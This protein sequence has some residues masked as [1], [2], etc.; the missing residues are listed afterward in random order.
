MTTDSTAVCIPVRG[1][2]SGL[3]RTLRSIDNL[4]DSCIRQI[5]VSVDG[6]DDELTSLARDA[7]ADTVVLPR[8]RGPSA[9][10]NAAIDALSDEIAIVMFTDAGCTID[11]GWGAEHRRTL[12]RVAMSGG[13]VVVELSSRPSPA[14]VVDAH[15]NLRQE[16][17]IRHTGFAA[18]CNLAVRRSVVSAVRFDE[19]QPIYGEDLD[20]C[21][22]A[23]DAGFGLEYTRE[24]VVRH[25]ARRRSRSVVSKARRAGLGMASL[26]SRSRPAVPPRPRLSREVVRGAA[27]AGIRRGW[28]WQTRVILLDYQRAWAYRR[29]FIRTLRRHGDPG[30]T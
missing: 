17:Y 26:P 2:R 18:T 10:R 1:D 3:I 28:W 23:A 25:A 21:H 15:R 4:K 7:G 29:A 11:P 19:N 22:R 16:D 6:P 14:E 13:G 12:E 24:A 9:A 30:R 20:F 8:W 5:V 27:S